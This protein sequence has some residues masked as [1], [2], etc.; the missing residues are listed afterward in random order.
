MAGIGG[1]MFILIVLSSVLT[2]TVQEARSLRL[3]AVSPAD[4]PEA[5]E[6]AHEEPRGTFVIVLA[7]LA[8]FILVYFRNWW[9]L[10]FRSWLVH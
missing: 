6:T 8:F 10:G 5:A 2:G 7:F 3:V 9:L 1:A 4:P